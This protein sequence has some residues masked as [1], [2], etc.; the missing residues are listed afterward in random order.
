M[1]DPYK[2]TVEEDTVAFTGEKNLHF[3]AM[4][5]WI[6]QHMKDWIQKH[7]TEAADRG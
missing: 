6:L 4:R 2:H 7:V 5:D 1:E 3:R